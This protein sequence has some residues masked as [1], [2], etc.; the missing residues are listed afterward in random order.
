MKTETRKNVIKMDPDNFELYH[1]KV[2]AY[3]ETQCSNSSSINI[4]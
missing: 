1:F 4:S 3:F 2:G